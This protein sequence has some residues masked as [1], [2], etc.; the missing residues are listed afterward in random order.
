MSS[1]KNSAAPLPVSGPWATK[2]GGHLNV[3]FNFDRAEAREY[4]EG[5]E[6]EP[7]GLRAYRVT[8]LKKGAI[9]G[10]E[11]H[12][13]RVEMAFVT[14][15]ALTWEITA[16]DGTESTIES[17]PSTQGV[18]IYPNTLHT[19]HVEEDDTEILVI[20]NTMFDPNDP[21]THDTYSSDSFVSVT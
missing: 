3:L 17:S 9:G 10:N 13:A 8:G 6:D 7:S 1:R 21:S 15:G 4:I 14:R 5:S 20:T 11:W 12:K 16:S 2:S 19:Y 18:I